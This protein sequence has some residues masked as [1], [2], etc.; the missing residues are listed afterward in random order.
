MSRPVEGESQ[1]RVHVLIAGRVQGVCFRMETRREAK[2]LGVQGWVRNRPDGRVEGL[3]EGESS[4]VEA[5][6]GWCEKGPRLSRVQDVRI[7]EEPPTGEF[8]EFEIR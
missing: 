1:R 6:V 8:R 4:A 2:R 3:F 7:G 5:L